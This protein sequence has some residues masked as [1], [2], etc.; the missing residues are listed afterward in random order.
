MPPSLQRIESF[1]SYDRKT[2]QKYTDLVVDMVMLVGEYSYSSV[3]SDDTAFAFGFLHNDTGTPVLG[4]GSA[5][6]HG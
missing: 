6:K 4:N 1:V 3:M 5:K 2:C